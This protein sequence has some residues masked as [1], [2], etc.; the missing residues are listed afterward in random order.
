[1]C[2]RDSVEPPP[3]KQ[4]VKQF[5]DHWVESTAKPRL[6][7]RTYIGY[8]QHV[9]VH[10][11]PA[12]GHLRLHALSP[13]QVQSMLAGLQ[14]KKL[15]PRTTRGVRAVLRAALSN[16]IRWGLVATFSRLIACATGLQA[17]A[18]GFFSTTSESS[19]G[20]AAA[21]APLARIES[22]PG[23]AKVSCLRICD[24]RKRD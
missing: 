12:L 6:R 18:E 13:Q 2:I 23:P 9:D 14:L 10:I 22:R 20:S 17:R 5:L 11:V 19:F 7:P 3:A 1:M 16:A 24:F 4:T 8:K 21:R 15:A